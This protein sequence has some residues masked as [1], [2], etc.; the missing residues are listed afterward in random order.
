MTE[1]K[2][3]LPRGLRNNNP[4]NIVLKNTTWMGQVKNGT[5]KRF[6][7][8]E[9]AK[10]GWRAAFKLLYRYY[11]IY[12]LNTI[13][14]IVSRWAPTNEND[15]EDYIRTVCDLAGTARDADLG[16]MAKNPVAWMKLAMAMGRVENGVA[17][18]MQ[19]LLDG[20]EMFWNEQ[21]WRH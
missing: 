21:G 14:M 8:F 6:C 20:Y 18:D 13:E 2:E 7:Q 1:K 19:P 16:H 9:D 15:T 5:D 11:Y 12:R 10:Y 17:C 4:L 3:S